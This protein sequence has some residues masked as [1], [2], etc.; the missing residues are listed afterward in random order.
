MPSIACAHCKHTKE[1]NP[2]HLDQIKPNDLTLCQ[3]CGEVSVIE[4]GFSCRE[5]NFNDWYYMKPEL[6]TMI[7]A[8]Q[9]KIKTKIMKN[10]FQHEA[11]SP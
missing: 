1:I 4:E 9:R 8:Y 5:A 6:Y 3:V 11:K 2:A 10:I 7:D